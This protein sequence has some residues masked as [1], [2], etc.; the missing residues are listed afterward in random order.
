[1]AD[2]L[3]I[4]PY[5]GWRPRSMRN[6]KGGGSGSGGESRNAKRSRVGN[7]ADRSF[8]KNAHAH[9]LDPSRFARLS[10]KVRKLNHGMRG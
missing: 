8:W 6:G 7:G 10:E 2:K 5:T 4:P 1:M 9:R 3:E